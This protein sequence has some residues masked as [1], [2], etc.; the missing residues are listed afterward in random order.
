MLTSTIPITVEQRIRQALRQK[1]ATV[2]V[3]RLQIT[4]ENGRVTLRGVLRTP[5]EILLVERAAWATSGVYSVR[6]HLQ[7]G[8]KLM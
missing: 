5:A 2:D 4:E 8:Y 3:D 7:T 6:N 1:S